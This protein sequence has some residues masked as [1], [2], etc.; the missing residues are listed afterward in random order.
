MD[1]NMKKVILFL[2][3]AFCVTC[4]SFAAPKGEVY[5]VAVGIS[6]YKSIKDLS[7]PE[8]DAKAIADLYKTHTKNVILITGKYATKKQILKSLKDQFSRATADD[9]IV[10]SFSGHGFPGGL[11]PYDMIAAIKD[12]GIS[13]KEIQAIF[14]QSKA[15]RKIMLAD[16][17]YSGGI[18]VSSGDNASHK[19]TTD[20][21]SI[22]M[23]L[24]SRNGE[25][26]LEGKYMVN[27]FFTTYLLRGLRGG[28]DVD[29]NKIITA[30]ELF[31]FVSEGVKEKSGDTQHPVMWGKFDDNYI[32]MDWNK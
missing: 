17:C 27:G 20:D 10:F 5:V 11:C 24:S 31:K 6:N 14:K 9:V 8:N 15:K 29:R 32:I 18:R 16:A 25:V 26:S 28:A 21:S 30:K 23:F 1:I 2:L 19:P 12:T 13:Y 3:L 7:L 22:L 4:V